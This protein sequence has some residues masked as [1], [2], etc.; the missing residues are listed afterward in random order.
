MNLHKL[1]E[2]AGVDERILLK[3]RKKCIFIQR[4]MIIYI[5]YTKYKLSYRN[6]AKLFNCSH[7]SIRHSYIFYKNYILDNDFEKLYYNKIIKLI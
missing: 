3:C 7:I 6:I 4:S 5:L 2:D 1:C